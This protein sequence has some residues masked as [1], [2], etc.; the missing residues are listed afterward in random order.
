VRKNDKSAIFNRLRLCAIAFS[1]WTDSLLLADHLFFP[2]LTV[3]LRSGIYENGGILAKNI[4]MKWSC[5]KKSVTILK[6][7]KIVANGL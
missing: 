2:L 7:T 6:V 1:V 5:S 3:W 4:T